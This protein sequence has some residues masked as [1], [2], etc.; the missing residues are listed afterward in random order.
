MRRIQP[1][2]FTMGCETTEV[3]YYGYEAVS[4]EVTISLPFYIGVFVLLTGTGGVMY[5]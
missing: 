4:H 2:T 1:G 5:N 3:G